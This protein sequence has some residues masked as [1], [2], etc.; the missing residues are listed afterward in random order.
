[1]NEQWYFSLISKYIDPNSPA[2][3]I[4]IIHSTLVTNKALKIADK[5]G[6]NHDKLKFIEEA[7][8]LHDIGVCK[9]NDP[10]MGTIGGE[11]ITHGIIGSD[12]L[13]NEGYPKHARVAERHTGVGIYKQEII[14]KGLPL[15]QID[16]I[17][18]TIEERIISYSDLFF[19]KSKS[20]IWHERSLDEV[21]ASISKFG[22]RY[23]DILEEWIRE[24]EFIHLR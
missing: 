1:M 7:S 15:P 6:L 8:M 5:L 18:E 11:Y 13:I 4:Y 19:S 3:P 17:P 23:V 16:L 21:R 10:D 24:F 22:Q 12:I 2:Y 9:V 14:E 20:R